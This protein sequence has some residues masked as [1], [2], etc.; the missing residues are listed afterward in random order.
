MQADKFYLGLTRQPTLFG[1]PL[2]FALINFLINIFLFLHYGF[3]TLI[4]LCIIHSIF[5]GNSINDIFY[6]NILYK[7]FIHLTFRRDFLITRKKK[8]YS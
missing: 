1:V 3:I 8:Y 7:K 5:Y 4:I 2:Y 6:L